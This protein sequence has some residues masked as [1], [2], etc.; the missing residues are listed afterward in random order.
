[1]P[2]EKLKSKMKSSP[3]VFIIRHGSTNLNGEGGVSE[4][5]I[6]GWLDVPLN[7]S[8]REDAKKAAKKLSKESPS[9]IYSSDLVRAHETASIINQE[10][11]VPIVTTKTLRPWGLGVFQGKKTSDVIDELNHL[12]LNDNEVPKDGESFRNFR[13]RYLKQVKAI[14]D[15]AISKNTTLF[16]VSHFRNCKT[17]DAWEAKGFPSDFSI[18]DKVMIEDNVKPG[19]VIQINL[20]KYKGSL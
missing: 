12:V 1:M 17:Y 11:G 7:S 15:E 14:M 20:D 10:F 6:R 18:S 13:E 5:R 9:K 2:F 8:G 19:E 4:D 16:I 3:K